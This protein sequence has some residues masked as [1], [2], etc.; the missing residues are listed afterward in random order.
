MRSVT[1]FRRACSASPLAAV[2][3][4]SLFALASVTP[5]GAATGPTMKTR[6]TIAGDATQGDRLF[7]GHGSWS[8]KGSLS[9]AYRWYRCDTMGAHCS[10]LRGV[11]RRSHRLGENDVGHTVSVAVRATDETGSTTAFASLVGPIAGVPPQLQSKVR[12]K[13][14]GSVAEGATVRVAPGI[15]QPRPSSLSFQWARCNAELRDCTA[16]AGATSPSHDIVPDDLGHVLVAIVQ[17]RAGPGARALFSTA[18]TPLVTPTAAPPPKATPPKPAPPKPSP[19]AA[20]PAPAKPPAAPKPPATAPPPAPA[21]GAGPSATVAPAV[22]EVLQVGKQLTGA[23]GTWSGSGSIAY[24]YNWFRCDAAGAHCL[25]VHGA[26][27]PTLTLTDKDV[28]HTL[29]FAVHAAD[30]QGSSTAYAGLI[31]PVAAADAVVVSSGQ[32]A[33]SGTAAAGQTLQVSN[34]AWT[35]SPTAFGY[36]WL[37]CNGNGRLCVPIDGATGAS[38]A[39][40]AAD[41]GHALVAVVHATAGGAAQDALSNATPVVP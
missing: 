15:W 35:G 19:P 28:G 38:Y 21:E 41:G 7:V 2:C 4:A 20:T 22:A 32:P 34:G 18:T 24:S 5:A 37:R 14:S 27:L 8:G 11:D 1:G 30:K 31:G 12:P 6:P 9:Y 16:I 40:T 3:G 26:T 33:I 25:S 36:Q 23:A 17:A 10:I 29:G 13:V 39:V